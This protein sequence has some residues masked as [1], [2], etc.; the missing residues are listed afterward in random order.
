MH[1]RTHLVA[2]EVAKLITATRGTRHAIRDRCLLLWMFR[3]G[4]RVAEACGLQL[5]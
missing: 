3:H 1:D 5:S 2:A 4:W